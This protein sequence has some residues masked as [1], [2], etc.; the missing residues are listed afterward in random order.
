MFNGT[1]LYEAPLRGMKSNEGRT[2]KGRGGFPILDYI[3][4]GRIVGELTAHIV[5]CYRCFLPDLTG[6]TKLCCVRPNKTANQRDTGLR[7]S[8][9]PS[10]VPPLA[11]YNV[12]IL[13][14]VGI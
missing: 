2:A 5:F 12:L 4:K 6:F 10:G 13:P 1:P 11:H 14:Q 7:N 9:Q 8:I 3:V